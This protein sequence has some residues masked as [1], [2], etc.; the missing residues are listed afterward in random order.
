MAVVSCKKVDPEL[1]FFVYED[2][3]TFSEV[4]MIDIGDVGATEISAYKYQTKRMFVVNNGIVNKIDIL[5]FAYPKNIKLI[6]SISTL[7]YGGS[8]N[9]VAVN[10]GKTAAAIE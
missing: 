9:S 10:N 3:A 2:V 6:S 8:V 7:P 4:G 1:N 5:D